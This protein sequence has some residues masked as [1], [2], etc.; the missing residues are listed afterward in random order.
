MEVRYEAKITVLKATIRGQ[1]QTMTC[2]KY[3]KAATA[4]R[5]SFKGTKSQKVNG[6]KA[7]SMFTVER[8]ILKD[9]L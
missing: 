2:R 6:E 3:K 5:Y 1:K 8:D 7:V 4:G 9:S